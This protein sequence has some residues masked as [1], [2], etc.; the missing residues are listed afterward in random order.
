MEAWMLSTLTFFGMF[1]NLLLA[2]YSLLDLHSTFWHFKTFN[3]CLSE[4]IWLLKK[5]TF[6]FCSIILKI[7]LIWYGSLRQCRK[8]GYMFISA[9]DLMS[10]QNG[11]LGTWN[12]CSFNF[13]ASIHYYIP[14]S[15]WFFFFLLWL[16][17][18]LLLNL[19]K[20]NSL[21]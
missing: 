17:H 20:M 9:L 1:M 15:F 4:L 6:G 16:G 13:V 8:W 2:M 3:P 19:V 10:V 5:E 21:V 7:D 11:I 12:F 18:Y 14:S